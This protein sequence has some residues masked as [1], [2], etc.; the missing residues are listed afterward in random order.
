MATKAPKTTEA[1]ATTTPAQVF[2]FPAFDFS[3]LEMPKFEVPKFDMSKIEV[4]AAMRE[5]TD[6]AVSQAKEAYAKLKTVAEEAT[7]LVEDTYSTASKGVTEFNLAALEA[8]RSNMN[9][10]FDHVRDVFAIKTVA[11]LVELQSAFMR[12]QFEAVQAQVKDLGGI[13]QKV[14]TATAEPVKEK[15]EKTMSSLKAA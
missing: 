6:K 13:A 7:D 8:S 3:K 12:K 15:F 4:P 10:T 2:P 11:E 1:A 5:A 9:A 14:A